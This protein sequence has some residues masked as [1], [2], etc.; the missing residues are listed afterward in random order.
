MSRRSRRRAF[1]SGRHDWCTLLFSSP[2]GRLPGARC[3][4]RLGAVTVGV[5]G[6]VV[7]QDLLRR[8]RQVDPTFGQRLLHRRDHPV[9][10]GEQVRLARRMNPPTGAQIHREVTQAHEQH[11]G[12]RVRQH[13]LR[14]T[15]H[16]LDDPS[17]SLHIVAVTDPEVVLETPL[18][19][20]GV[21]DHAVAEQV[22]VGDD[23]APPV[24]GLDKGG[25]GLYLLDRALEAALAHDDL[26][27]DPEGL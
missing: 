5:F 22:G 23:H 1:I 2:A 4:P 14:T 20:G 10:D 3:P 19:I 16:I 24:V 11:L 7:Q 8:E 26:V 13:P 17:G 21:D 18:V 6:L 9:L 12:R 25:A 27:A 15:Q